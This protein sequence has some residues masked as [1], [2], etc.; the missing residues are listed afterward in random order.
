[1]FSKGEVEI[2][3]LELLNY[4]GFSRFSIDFAG[5]AYLVGPNNA[6]KSTVIHALQACAGMIDYAY[7][8]AP[9]LRRLV[10]QEGSKIW[11]RAYS[12][13]RDNFNLVTENIRHEFEPVEV[14]IE[15]R[16]TNNSRLHVVWPSQEEDDQSPFFYFDIPKRE[17]PTR[18]KEVAQFFPRIGVVP[19]L[20]PIE[21]SEEVLQGEYIRRNI[22]G[23][24]ASRHFRNQLY[25]LLGRAD[26]ADS[27]DRYKSFV[28]E[29]TPEIQLKDIHARLGNSGQ[30]LD[31]YFREP[32][33][34]TDKEL[35][36]AGDGLQI[37]L[38]LLFHLERLRDYSIVLLD[39]PEVYLH[40]D[41]QRRLVRILEASGKQTIAATHSA[42]VL[43][44]S[45]PKTAIIVDR[46]RNRAVKI[47]RPEEISSLSELLGS[48]FNL[49][50][51]RVLRARAVVFVEGN[52]FKMLRRMA[53]LCG[54]KSLASEREM[55]LIPMHGFSN[56]ENVLPF[57]WLI[58]GLLEKS[59]PVFVIVDRDYRSEKE[60]ASVASKLRGE[61]VEPIIW[62]RKELESYL[63]ETPLIS[64]I[65]GA[66][67]A[68]VE[69][70]M[71]EVLESKKS[72]VS[73][74][75]IAERVRKKNKA[76][77]IES[78]V[79]M[80]TEEFDERW[81]IPDERVKMY[82]PKEVL[83]VLNQRLV[84]S[85]FKTLSFEALSYGA[86]ISDISNEVSVALLR[87]EAS[88]TK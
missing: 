61:G 47:Q 65:S 39:E 42:E 41:L 32:F 16:F 50:L 15:L 67:S 81:K 45:N 76:E 27:F 25:D 48:Q 14:K 51:A 34:R 46:R 29:W 83:P 38:Q 78:I 9:D 60:M 73:S 56:W 88:L 40:A 82:P 53:L 62:V 12:F 11:V 1:M 64:R 52:D 59:I 35:F 77:S 70:N 8:K 43:G 6:G 26:G 86:I 24:L 71:A 87:I 30:E 79:K 68:W 18:P 33:S 19:A 58:K 74:R 17:Q 4:K 37:W 80:V 54:A 49:R 21:A 66:P 13:A 10:R 85:G 20:Q 44:E 72:L 63:L 28:Q 22:D 69:K 2:K 57:Q 55:A 5:P 84:K 23:K 75:M 36:W 7:V 3:K 31:L